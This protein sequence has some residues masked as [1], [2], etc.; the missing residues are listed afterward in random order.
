MIRARARRKRNTRLKKLAHQKESGSL[1]VQLLEKALFSLEESMAEQQQPHQ[2]IE[3]TWYAPTLPHPPAW[4][5]EQIKSSNP[6]CDLFN[7]IT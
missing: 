4:T 6:T 2:P 3:T 1:K 5:Q 7:N